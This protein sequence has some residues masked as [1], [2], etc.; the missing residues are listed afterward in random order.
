MPRYAD[1]LL[2]LAQPTYSFS[3]P[4]GMKLGVGDAVAVQFGP[5]NIHTGIVWRLHDQ[6]PDFKRIKSVGRRLY[7]EPLLDQGQMR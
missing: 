7:S 3:V 2:P 1:I 6:K 4:E 5:R